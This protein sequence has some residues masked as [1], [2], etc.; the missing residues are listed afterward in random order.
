[1]VEKALIEHEKTLHVLER[2]TLV[3]G[4]PGASNVLRTDREF[5]AFAGFEVMVK[6]SG[7]EEEGGGGGGSRSKG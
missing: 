2:H 4:T 3:V 6:V 5:R 1:M 7:K